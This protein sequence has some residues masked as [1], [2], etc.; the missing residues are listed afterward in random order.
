MVAIYGDRL[1]TRQKQYEEFQKSQSFY[2]EDSLFDDE[3]DS[4]PFLDES[5]LD[6]DE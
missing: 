2:D 1:K 5:E 6:G 4:K 3:S